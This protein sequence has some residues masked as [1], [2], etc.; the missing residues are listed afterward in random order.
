MD[1]L[2]YLVRACRNG[3]PLRTIAR[4]TRE[5]NGE[6]SFRGTIAE[7][8]PQDLFH[9]LDRQ[10]AELPLRMGECVYQH[11]H[12]LFRLSSRIRIGDGNLASSLQIF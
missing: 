4:G 12:V 7:L 1:K 8:I 2:D 9:K 3:E 6:L 10:L 11:G 5:P